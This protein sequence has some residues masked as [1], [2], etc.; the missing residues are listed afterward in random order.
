MTATN[1]LFDGGCQTK[2]I[3][4]PPLQYNV[5]PERGVEYFVVRRKWK[6]ETPPT[7][8]SLTLGITSIESRLSFKIC[9]HPFQGWLSLLATP[10]R[11]YIILGGASYYFAQPLYKC[12]FNKPQLRR[13]CNSRQNITY[14]I[15]VFTLIL[16]ILASQNKYRWY[17]LELGGQKIFSDSGL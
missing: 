7:P 5:Q 2:H 6:E 1:R 9:M 17:K 16:K 10:K 8:P 11:S 15:F 13:E 14:V 12:S 4:K 3:N